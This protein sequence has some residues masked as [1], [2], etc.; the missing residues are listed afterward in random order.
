MAKK[1]KDKANEQRERR[2]K[3][4]GGVTTFA[5]ELKS[6]EKLAD[7]RRTTVPKV[8]AASE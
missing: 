4:L 1:L 6:P 2:N 7:E 8:E 5:D 3:P